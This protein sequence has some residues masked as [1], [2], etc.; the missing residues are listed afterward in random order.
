MM[1]LFDDSWCVF[2][3]QLICVPWLLVRC[4]WTN[5]RSLARK[6]AISKI[7][8]LKN[9]TSFINLARTNRL[10][11]F[12]FGCCVFYLFRPDAPGGPVV[13]RCLLFSVVY[14][15]VLVLLLLLRPRYY[16]WFNVMM[17]DHDRAMWLV[18]IFALLSAVSHP[19]QIKFI[20]ISIDSV[21]SEAL[22]YS[23][24]SVVFWLWELII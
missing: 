24:G 11:Q 13:F 6:M 22:T 16:V 15:F 4:E 5:V 14:F 2:F 20:I 18:G 19:V 1:L 10:H 9:F 7:D 17:V 23:H 21:E 12:F 3:F 8:V